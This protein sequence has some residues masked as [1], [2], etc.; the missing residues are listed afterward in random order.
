MQPFS[1]WLQAQ[2]QRAQ[3]SQTKSGGQEPGLASLATAARAFSCPLLQEQQPFAGRS[4]PRHHPL[5]E[6]APVGSEAVDPRRCRCPQQRVASLRAA[7]RLLLH[8]H[9]RHHRCHAPRELCVAQR[10]LLLELMAVALL[11]LLLSWA[12]VWRRQRVWAGAMR[13]VVSPWA[14][15]LWQVRVQELAPPFC[16][17]RPAGELAAK[18][19]EMGRGRD[20]AVDTLDIMALMEEAAGL[21]AGLGGGGKG[22]LLLFVAALF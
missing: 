10:A 1:S 12:T 14:P 15:P 18:S 20:N 11:M 4:L 16:R 5:S 17:Q 19:D 6:L 9:H 2:L 3:H 13:Q 8:L 22:A 7:Q 21:G